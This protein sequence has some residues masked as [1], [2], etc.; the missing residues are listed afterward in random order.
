[1]K[2][3]IVTGAFPPDINPRS[4]R[5]AE[6]A[7]QFAREGNEVIVTN[8][9]YTS[10]FDYSELEKQMGIKVINIPIYYH[11]QNE[12]NKVLK[13]TRFES[14]IRKVLKYF[15]SGKLFYYSRLIAKNLYIE[16]DT[17]LII[18]VSVPFVTHL[19]VSKYR[20]KNKKKFTGKCFVADSGDP[21]STCQ[22]FKI[23]PYFKL[24]ER[25]VLKQFDYM[26]I[27][28]ELAIE[29]YTDLLPLSKIKIIPQGFDFEIKNILPPYVKNNVP[30][31]AYAGVFYKGIRNPEFLF[32]YLSELNRPFVFNLF[33]REKDPFVD[34]ILNKYH[35]ALKDK[36]YVYY[37]MSRE[38]LLP[39]LAMMDFMI[40]IGN[41][42]R[43]QVPSKIIDYALVNRPF[44]SFTEKNF[45]SSLFLDFMEG[46]FSEA[47]IVQ[48]LNRYDIKN[49]SNQ[50]L[51]LVKS[52]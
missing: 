6:L 37:G 23:A 46:N 34:S 5:S 49:V 51:S 39:K 10:G 14:L 30:T 38:N 24:L 20:R 21:F 3:H 19:A 28:T 42:T 16:K 36:V 22:Q 2:I 32:K 12:S 35:Y 47:E 7:K 4:F 31:F 9:S 45:N 33:L 52:K 27:P 44:I 18:S 50:F 1:M 15:T 43:V 17:D 13:L 41:A 48:N 8:L 25:R 40:N 11:T 26:S 29:A